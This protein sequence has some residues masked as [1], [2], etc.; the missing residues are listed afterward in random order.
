M[1]TN[2]NV[3]NIP[4]N[5]VSKWISAEY[6]MEMYERFKLKPAIKTVTEEIKK[7]SN[8]YLFKSTNEEKKRILI[9]GTKTG[10]I[11]FE[12]LETFDEAIGF[13]QEENH[14]QIPNE[15]LNGKTISYEVKEEGDININKTINKNFEALKSKIEKK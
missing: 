12:L 7:F 11:N 9:L 5:E 14:F 13:G 10:G 1:Q 2:K 4:Q 15:I 6:E 8:E 3:I